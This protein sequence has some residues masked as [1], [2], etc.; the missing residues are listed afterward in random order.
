[1][2]TKLTELLNIEYPI[3]QGGMAWIATGELAGGVSEAGGLGLVAGGSAPADVVRAEI[4]KVREITDKP[5]GVNIMLLSPFAD[6][7]AQLVIDE[8]VPV[9]TTGAGN[10]GIYIGKWKDAG[11]KVV[12]VI[13][14]VAY[15]KRMQKLGADAVVAEGSE[16]GGHIGETTTMALVPQVCDAVDIPVIAAGGVADGRGLAAVF[17]LGASGAQV[18]TRFLVANE[19]TVHDNYKQKV[20]DS[21]DTDSAVTGRVTGH[22]VRVIKNRLV[23]EYRELDDKNATLE[24]YEA[25]GADRLRKAA[26]D[27]DV[28]YGSVMA[29]QIA[30]M[31]KKRQSAKEII[32][33]ICEEAEKL[34]CGGKCCE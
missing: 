34:M 31:I 18:G 11:I 20:I 14:S 27:G 2:K 28:Q 23:R 21:R 19:C 22:P 30:G 15:A 5:F 13:A 29:G 6:D 33:E 16:A 26:K 32:V 12:P 4:R 7:L 1:M 9:V 8:K 24:E 25:L 10:P 3:V 17:M